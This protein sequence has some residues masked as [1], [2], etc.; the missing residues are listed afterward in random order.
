[1][2]DDR[3]TLLPAEPDEHA[4]AFEQAVREQGEARARWERLMAL[5]ATPESER[6]A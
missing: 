1:M 5:L 4:V 3:E 6:A 2:S